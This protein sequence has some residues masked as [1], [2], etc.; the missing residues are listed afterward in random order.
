MIEL[1]LIILLVVA[2]YLLVG[3]ALL[4]LHT[5]LA[6]RQVETEA[7]QFSRRIQEI[8]RAAQA[9]IVRELTEGHGRQRPR[10]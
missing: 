5:G 2:G 9:E 7:R 1:A 8:N 10:P 4:G 3:Q 6:R